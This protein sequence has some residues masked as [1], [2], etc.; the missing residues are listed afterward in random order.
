MSF[1]RSSTP[2]MPSPVMSASELGVGVGEVVGV[3]DVEGVGVVVGEVP[4]QLDGSV[5]EPFGLVGISS[6]PLL[7]GGARQTRGLPPPPMVVG[8]LLSIYFKSNTTSSNSD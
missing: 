4:S 8:E 6:V 2:T 7:K 3:G 1:A 5:T